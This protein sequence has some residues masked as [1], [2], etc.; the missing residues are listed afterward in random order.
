LG[1]NTLCP[2]A[3]WFSTLVVAAAL[4]LGPCGYV[5]A[6]SGVTP[7]TQ[8][9]VS[10]IGQLLRQHR[11][12]DAL[13]QCDLGLRAAPRDSRLWTLRG[14]ASAGLGNNAEALADYQHA[15]RY[16]PDYLPAL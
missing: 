8:S 3:K 1:K 4:G 9:S 15:L 12:Q 13:S 11:F 5:H 2:H 10:Q 7:A 14:M 16:T 6:Q